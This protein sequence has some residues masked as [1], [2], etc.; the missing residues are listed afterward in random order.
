ML[1]YIGDGSAIVGIPARDL[2]DEE[3]EAAGGEQLL[4]ASGLYAK[5]VKAGKK[6]A[7]ATQVAD[8]ADASATHVAEV[9]GGG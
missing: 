1:S 6:V 9:S 8:V 7:S 5:P 3:V 2:S 4:L